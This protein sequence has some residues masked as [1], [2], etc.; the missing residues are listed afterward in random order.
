[1]SHGRLTLLLAKA[2]MEV[3]L[4]FLLVPRPRLPPLPLLPPF[5][6]SAAAAPDDGDAVV[7]DVLGDGGDGRPTKLP[8]PRLAS[9]G[10]KMDIRKE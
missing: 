2:V 7:G 5:L 10:E 6:R 3:M 8:P 9:K 1:M 4:R